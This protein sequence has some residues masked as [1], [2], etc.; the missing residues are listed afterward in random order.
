MRSRGLSREE[1]GRIKG[2]VSKHRM[3]LA[4]IR[5]EKA[6]SELGPLLGSLARACGLD[7]RRTVSSAT[8]GFGIAELNSKERMLIVLH[9]GGPSTGLVS[10]S[11]ADEAFLRDVED[12]IFASNYHS[13]ILREGL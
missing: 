4:V 3:T 1:T 2:H 11:E 6:P 12:S 13:G 7:L 10:V 8:S 9:V 5:T